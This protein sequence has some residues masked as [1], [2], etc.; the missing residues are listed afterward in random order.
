MCRWVF[1]IVLAPLLWVY[2]LWDQSEQQTW[3]IDLILAIFLLSSDLK[4][5]SELRFPHG[6]STTSSLLQSPSAKKENF[7]IYVR[8]TRPR[9]HNKTNLCCTTHIFGSAKSTYLSVVE[10]SSTFYNCHFSPDGKSAAPQ[11]AFSRRKT[12]WLLWIGSPSACCV[13][14]LL[15]TVSQTP[16]SYRARSSLHQFDLKNCGDYF[17]VA[18][19]GTFNTQG[20]TAEHDWFHEALSLRLSVSLRLPLLKE[21]TKWHC[22]RSVWAFCF[23]EWLRAGPQ[24]NLITNR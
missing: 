8:H 23:S 20:Q 7:C 1:V 3:L 5:S 18:C 11:A 21:P 6:A 12:P 14:S 2:G 19:T 10:S 17:V 16:T 13:V 9:P 4:R 22:S 15:L 24:P